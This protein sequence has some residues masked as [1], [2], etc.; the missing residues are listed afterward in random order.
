M[1]RLG[2]GAAPAT[3]EATFDEAADD[4]RS[5]LVET[6]AVWEGQRDV[7]ASGVR[8]RVA[9]TGSGP[10]VVLLH[11]SFVDHSTWDG[12]AAELA[13]ELRIIAPDFPGFGES[14]KPPPGR[15]PYGVDAFAEAIADL[16]AGLDIGRA[17]VVGHAL[18][19]AVALTLAARHPELVERLVLVAP[20]CEPG[21]HGLRSRLGLWPLVGGLVFR[22]LW[23]RASFRS[24]FRSTMVSR[25]DAV[26]TA[27][28]DR[29]FEL[30]SSPLARSA[31]L[32]TLRS[33]VDTRPVIAQT[34]RLAVPTL[35]LWGRRD[36]VIAAGVG[37]RL[38]REIP[39]ANF[40]LLPAGHAPQEERP[41]E[42]A[43]QIARF[44]REERPSRL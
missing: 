12:V 23:N 9:T 2:E 28:I 38:A 5:G 3:P 11:G 16:Y 31:A 6:E 7:L 36:A 22:Q 19:G 32:A 4:R 17:S 15:F 44:L 24:F 27:R 42:L 34:T 43:A 14:E 41:A 26:P 8:L 29:Y 35:V 13:G 30:F 10:A 33:S 39:G 21:N 18:G 1:P 40:E 25:A 37:Q 20:L